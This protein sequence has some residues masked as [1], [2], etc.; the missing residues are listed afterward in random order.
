M[1]SLRLNVCGLFDVLQTFPTPKIFFYINHCHYQGLCLGYPIIT[2]KQNFLWICPLSY[3]Q[4][5]KLF[6]A[7]LLFYG[8]QTYTKKS[9]ILYY[10]IFIIPNCYFNNA[11]CSTNNIRSIPLVRQFFCEWCMP[12]L[13]LPIT[14]CI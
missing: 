4:L 13:P 5:K 12:L 7:M 8:G 3:Y 6:L 11:K 10:N 1:L 14:L 2:A 9:N